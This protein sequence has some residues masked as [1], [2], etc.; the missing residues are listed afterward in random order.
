M[1][2]FSWVKSEAGVTL[3]EVLASITILFI[4]IVSMLPMFVQS[5]RSNSHSK[6]I[7]DATYVAAANMETVY[8][9]V[10]TEPTIDSAATKLAG[11]SNL[12]LP[13]TKDCAAADKCFE[14]SDGGHYVFLQLKP[15][16]ANPDTVQL[17]VK[18]YKDKSKAMKKAQME[19][20]VLRN[21]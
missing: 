9:F 12:F 6:T 14:K 15:S 16:A 4:I 2:K 1:K 10:S 11:P 21:K 19:T 13:T 20:F 7:M 8:H 18:V 3:V 5:T 17:K